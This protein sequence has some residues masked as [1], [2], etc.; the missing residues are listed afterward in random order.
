MEKRWCAVMKLPQTSAMYFAM[1]SDELSQNPDR[2]KRV[3]Q[4]CYTRAEALAVARVKA[5]E[6]AWRLQKK[7]KK[8]FG[9]VGVP[10]GFEAVTY[11]D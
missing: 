2:F 3:S 6:L 9:A 4:M 10:D 5:T 7:Y 1:D 11:S 8:S